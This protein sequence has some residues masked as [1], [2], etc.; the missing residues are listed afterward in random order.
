MCHPRAAIMP[1]H[2]EA[3]AAQ[4]A[5]PFHHIPRHGAEGVVRSVVDRRGLIV[6][7]DAVAVA[8]QVGRHHSPL[9]A[10]AGATLCHITCVCG[11]RCSSNNGGP[12][13]P[14][15]KTMRAPPEAAHCPRAKPSP[16]S[17]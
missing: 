11:L 1:I 12:E 6:R 13:P 15:Q 4:L 5:H 2:Q 10:S 14:W 8:T 17:R 9:R 7:P 16:R 3:L